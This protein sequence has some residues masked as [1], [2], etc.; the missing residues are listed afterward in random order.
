MLEI[1]NLDK[2]FNPNTPNEVRALKNVSLN[3]ERGLFLLIIGTNSGKST[4][5]NAVAGTFMADSGRITLA[6][7][8]ITR[9]P[10]HRRAKLIGAVPGP[11][12]GTAP[13]MS[14]AEPALAARAAIGRFG[15]ALIGSWRGVPRPH[16]L[17]EHGT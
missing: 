17:A 10:E 7:R 11:F 2:T 4:L 5:L 6:G 3:L 14:I 13:N 16:P 1:S 9:W 8:R 15:W 12:S